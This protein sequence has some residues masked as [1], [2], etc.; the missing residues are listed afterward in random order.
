MEAIRKIQTVK[1]GHVNVRLPR[2]FWGQ[3]VEIIVFSASRQ[4]ES[5]VWNKSLRECLHQTAYERIYQ[6]GALTF[7][8]LFWR[9]N[10]PASRFF[11][12]ETDRSLMKICSR[13]RS[14]PNQGYSLNCCMRPLPILH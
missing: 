6:L 12:K 14:P 9:A 1:D 5:I 13:G 10:V 8:L 4:D 3:Q 11:S 7:A 2:Q